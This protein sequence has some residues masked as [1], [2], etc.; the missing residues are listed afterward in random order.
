MYILDLDSM[1]IQM[2]HTRYVQYKNN[3]KPYMHKGA[4]ELNYSCAYSIAPAVA[5][6]NGLS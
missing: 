5:I 1:P 4:V 3:N 2:M 6:L